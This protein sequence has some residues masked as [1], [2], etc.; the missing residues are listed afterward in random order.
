MTF[1][2]ALQGLRALI[3]PVLALAGLAAAYSQ[4][5]VQEYY[6]PMPEAQIRQTFLALASNTGTTMDSTVSMVAAVSGTKIVYD[7]WEDGYEVNLDSPTQSTTEIWGDGN[8]ANGKPPGFAND[9]NG[10]P[11]GTVIALRNQ[12]ALPRNPSTFLYDGRDRVGA[13]RGIVMTRASWA[14]TPGAVLAG[15]AA[16]PSTLDWGTSF[17]IPVG[18]NEIYPTPVTSSMF[19]LTSLFVQASQP[20]TQVQIDKNADGVVDTT[21]TLGQ[22]ESYYVDRGVYRGATVVASKPVQVNIITGDI[23]G[24]YENRWYSIAPTAQWGTRYY[25]PVG[26][27]S[28]GNETFVFLYN[29]DSAA[30]TVNVTTRVGA[31][32]VSIPAKSNYI[33]QMPQDS[34]ASFINTAGKNF[35]AIATVGAKPTANNVYDWGFSLVQEADLTTSLSLGW[36]P[37]SS[38]TTPT[39]N[40]NPVWVTAVKNTTVYVDYNGDRAGSVTDPLGGKC[41]ASF[42]VSALQVLKLFDPDK[43]QTGMRVYTV[44]GT[45]IAGAWGE[46]P[47]TA[48]SGNPYLDAGTT[49]PA[50]PVPVVRKASAIAIDAN[51]AGLSIGDTLEYTITMDNAGLVALGNLLV[52]DALP[53]QVTYVANSTTRDGVAI[54]DGTTGTPFPLDGSGVNVPVLQRGQTTSFKYRATITS[55]G[56][57]SNTV[58]TSYAGVTSNNTVSVPGGG[59]A[60]TASFSVAAGTTTTSYAVGDGVYVTVT[61]PDANTSTTTVQTFTVI[62]KNTST[63]DYETITLT[64]TGVN[65]GI[66]R[67][68]TALPSSSTAGLGPN[69]GTLNVFS[70]NAL[71]VSYTDPIYGETA[72]ASATIAAATPT[73]ILY[74]STDGVGSPDQDLDRIDPVTSADSST[75][76]TATITT[77]TATVAAAATTSGGSLGPFSSLTVAHTTGTGTNRLMMVAVNYEDDDVAGMSITG[78]TYGGVALTR[79]A[80]QLSG[81]EASTQ[82][83]YLVNPASGTAN[84]VVNATG[85]QAADTMHVGVTTFTGVSQSAPFGTAV[86]ATGTGTTASVTA[87]SATGELVYATLALDDARAATTTSGQTEL[88]NT[89]VGTA[90]SDGIRSAATTKAGALATVSSWTT[91]SDA[92]ACI[93]VPIKP[94]TTTGSLTFTQTPVLAENLVIPSGS[95]LGAQAYFTATTG[96]MPASP[97]VTA[98]L[99][100]GSTTIATSSSASSSGGILTFT[101]PALSSAVTVPSGQSIALDIT[102]AVAGVVFRID[103]DS[104]TKPSRITL[105]TSTV[106]HVDSVGVYDAPYPN[107]T[108]VSA[109]ANGQVLYVRTVAGDPFG[110]YDITSLPLSIDG[111]GTAG[112]ISTTLTD[113]NVVASTASSKTYEYQWR[114]G[115]TTGAYSIVATAKEGLENTIQA[116]RS[117]S[118][119]LANLDVGTPSTVEFFTTGGASTLTYAAN[120][121]IVVRVTDLDENKNAAAVETVTVTV[122]SS[123]GDSETITLTETGVN[124]GIFTAT[125]PASA[126][127]VGTSN[128]GTLY[129]PT[130]SALGVTYVDPNDSTDVSTDS[131]TVPAATAVDGV[132]ITKTL[133]SPADGQAIAGEAVQFRLRVLNTGGT[134]L[135]TVSVTDTFPT[136]NLTY[137]SATTTPT[138][139]SGGTITWSNVGP[140]T[141][142]QAAEI[143]VNFTANAAGGTVTNSAAVTAGTASSN[144]SANLTITRPRVTV[145]KTVVSPASGTAGKGD[146]VVFSIAIQNSGTT[147]IPTLPL[148]DLY[149]GDTFEYV[150]SSLTP[151]AT[152]NGTILWNDITGSGSLAVGATQTL[153]V[154]LKVKGSANPAT[155]TAAVN[156]AVDANN[157]S[158]PATSGSA[159][160]VTSAASISGFT[161]EDKGVS[162]FGG[163]IALPGVA[164]TLYTDPNG[165]GNPSDGTV[166][167]ITTSL[168]DGSYEFLNLALGNYVVVESD[169]TGYSSVTDIDGVND[170]RIKVTLTTLTATTGRNFLDLYIDPAL[171]GTINGQV[172]NDTDGDGDLLDADTGISGVTVDLYTDPNGDGNPLDGTIYATATTNASGNYSFTLVPPGT[173]VVVETDLSGYASTADKTL[174]NDNRVPVTIAAS[175]TSAANDFLDSNNLTLLGTIGNTVWSDVNN[176]GLLD[177]GEAGIANVAVQLYKST[178]T[179]GTDTP[180]RTTTT[181]S[182]GVYSFAYVPAGSYVVY[183]PAANFATGGALVSA[184]LSSDFTDTADNQENN[185]DNGIQTASGQPVRSPVIAIAANETDNT[186]DF[187]FV[188]NTSLGSISGTVLEDTNNDNTGD[189]GIAGVT[190]TLYSDP[191]GDGNQADGVVKG[192]AVTAADG[193]Y[194][195]T[196]LPP[197]SYVVVETQP[198]GY[199]NVTDTD[200]GV[201]NKVARTLTAGGSLA[202]SFVEERPGTVTGHLYIDTNGNGTQ[203][204]GEPNLNGVTITITDSASGTVTTTTGTNGNW[205][206]SVQPGSASA[207]VDTASAQIPAGAVRTEGTDPTVVTVT[208]GGTVSAGND[209]FYQSATLSGLVYRDVNGNGAQN[210]GEPGLSGVKVRITDVLGV[211]RD[212]T[213]NASGVWTVTL[214][215][216]LATV[217][218]LEL[219]AT[220]PSGGVHGE[221]TDPNTVTAVAGTTTNGGTDGYYFPATVTGH[222]Y[223]DTNGD[224][225]QGAGEP[226]LANVDVVITASTGATQR[227]ATDSSGNWTASVPPGTT[228]ADID[229]TDP[230]YPAGATRT[231]GDDPT[232]FTAVAAQST[233]GGIDGLYIPATVTGHLYIDRNGNGTEDSGELPLAGVALVITDSRS[234][235]RNVTTDT[236]GNWTVSVPPGTTIADIVDADPNIPSGA[237]RTEGTDPTT[238]TAVAGVS[239]SAGKDGFYQAATLTGHL[240]I[241]TNGNGTQDGAETGLA[242]VDV[243]ITD[244]LGVVRVVSTNASGNWTVSVPPGSA[245]VD[246]DNSDPQFPAGGTISQGSDPQTVTAVAGASTP[247]ATVGYRILGLVTGHLYVDVNNNGNQDAGEPNLSNI[248]VLV[249]NSLSQTQTVST[250]AA[251]NWVASVP[252]GSTTAGIDNADPQFPAG[253]TLTQGSDPV[254]V[255]AVA[256][257]S[258]PTTAV[259][260]YISTLVTGTVFVDVNHNGARDN[261]EPG[262]AG[263]SVVVTDSNSVV[264]TVVTNSQ[265]VWSASVAPGATTTSITESGPAFPSGFV[266]TAGSATGSVTAV[267]GTPVSVGSTGY[268]FPGTLSGHL[269]SDTN[270]NGVE[271]PGEPGLANISVLITD[272]LGNTQTVVTGSNGNWTATV[273]PGSTVVDIDNNDPDLPAG[274]VRT[275]GVDPVTVTAVSGQNTSAGSGTGFYQAATVAG[276]LYRDTNGNG[277]QD[278]GEPDLAN[279]NVFVTSSTGATQTVVSGING[280]WTASVPPGTTTI[281]VDETDPQYPAGATQTQGVALTTV[282]AAAGTTVQSGA[283]GFFVP[284]V[285]TGHL[286]LDLNGNG[287]QDFVFHNLANVDVVVTDSLGNTR[288]VFTDANGDW[289]AIVPPGATTAVISS[290]DP[291]YPAGSVVTQGSVSTNFTAIAGA[292]TGST[293]VGFFFPAT[294][295]GRLYVDTNGNGVQDSGEPGLPNVDVL[296]T[297]A[298]NNTQRVT[299]DAS[300][301][302]TAT[303]PPGTTTIDIDN[304]DPQYPTGYQQTQGTDPT[305]VTA[306]ASTTVSAGSAGFYRSG[307]VSGHLFVDTNGN[308]VED[309]GEPGLANV[310]VLV[311]DVNGNTQTVTTDANGNWTATVPPGSTLVDIVD[312]DPQIPAGATRTAG[313]D[314]VTVT[315]VAGANTPAGGGAGYYQAATLAGLLYADTNGNGTRDAG[316]PGIAD[317]DV[318]VTDSLGTV[319]RVATDVNGAWTINIPPGS[320]TVDIDNAD[321]Q[322][323]AGVTQ[324]EGTD[325]TTVTAIAGQT[326]NAGNDAYYLP[327]TVTGLVYR[328]VNGDGSLNGS[329]AG[330]AGVKVRVTDSLGVVRVATTNG[331]GV[332]TVSVPPGDTIADVLELDGTFPDGAVHR[333]GTDPNTVV[334]VAGSSVDSGRDGYY[335]PATVTGF[336]FLDANGNGVKDA[337]E[338]GIADLDVVIT[339][340]NGAVQTVTTDGS[341]NWTATVPP[342]ATQVKVSESD[343]Q[344]PAGSQQTVGADPNTITAVANQSVSAGTDGFYIAAT[345]TGVVYLDANGNGTQQN[346]E[347]GIAGVSVTITDSLGNPHVVT[348]GGDGR[349]TAS[350]PPGVAIV[351]VDQASASIPSGSVQTQG[352][353]PSPVTAVAGVS[354]DAGKDGYFQPAV[355]SGH[356]YVDAN[357][358]GVQDGAE[359]GLADVDVTI[360][361]SLGVVRVVSTD[362]NGNWTVSVPPGS[363]LVDVNQ[364]DPQFPA[365]GTIS[366]GSDPQ[367]VT[368]VAGSNTPAGTIGYR[369]LGM[370]TGHLYV[371][372]NNNATQDPGEPNL[373]GIN[374][375]VTDTLGS[376]TVE[377]DAL[378]NWIANVAPGSVTADVDNADPQ[379]PTGATLTEGVDPV[380]VTAVAGTSVPTGNVGYYISTLVNGTIFVDVNHN[381]TREPNEPGLAGVSVVVTDSNNVV[382]T[383]VTNDQGVWSAGVA[384]GAVTTTIT[385]SSPL[386]TTGFVRTSGS[387]TGSV[388]ATAGTPTTVGAT[389]YYFPGTVS[390]SLYFDTNGNGQKDGVESFLAGVDLAITDSNGDLTIV[391]T[392]GNGAWSTTVAP[393]LV[394]IDVDENDPQF[395]AG[396]VQT[397]GVDPTVVTA[398]SGQNVDSGT[399]GF[400]VSALVSGHLYRDTNGNGT[401]D[402]GEPDL[403]G[404]N[405]FVVDSTG[406]NRT[407]VTGAD[408][409]WSASVPPG[410][411]R[412]DIDETDPQYPAGAT[413]TQGVALTTLTAVAGSEVSAGAAGYFVPAIVTGHLYLDLNGNGQ[414]DFVY[415]NLANVDILVTDSLGTTRTVTTDQNGDWRASVPPGTTF[416]TVDSTD[417]EYPTGSVVTQGSATTNFTAIAGATTGSTPVGFF[418]PATVS[419]RLYV[420]TNGNGQADP[421][422]PGLANVDVL[423]TSAI[424]NTQRV[425]T[426]ANGNWIATVPPGTT[427]IDIDNADPQFP[428]GYLQTQGTDPT[429]ITAVAS[430]TVSAGGAG[431]YLSGSVSGHLFVDTNGNG[432]ED[433][434]EP[435]LAGVDV[436]VTDSNGSTQTVTTDANGNWTAIVPPGSTTADIVDSDPQIPA[437]AIRTAGSD[438]VTVTAVAGV[439]TP[440]G[441]GAG[442]FQPAPLS[443]VVY[444]DTNGN[445]TRNADEPGIADVDVIVTDSLGTVRRVA[446]NANGGWSISVPPGTTTVDVDNA[447]PQFPAGV[448]LTEGIDPNTVTAIAGQVVNAGNDGYFLPAT[449]TGLVY[450]DA[451]GDGLQNGGEPGLAGVKVRVTDILGIPHDVTTDSNGNWTAVVPPGLTNVDVLEFDTTFPDGGVHLAGNDPNSIIAVAGTTVNGGTDGYYFPATV[452]G[453]LYLDVDGNGTQ[454]AG[455]PPLPNVD[456]V[457]TTS[458]GA[459]LRVT[460]DTNGNWSAS[461]PPGTTLVDVDETDP[462]F[463]A[464]STRTQGTDPT[465]VTAVA[466][467]AVS[468]GTNGYHVPAVITGLVYL[469]VNGNGSRQV[470][471]PGVAGVAVLLTDSLNN[472][473]TVYTAADGTWVASVPPGST[474][475]DISA[476]DPNLPSG[477]V[478]TEGTNP[479]TVITVAGTGTSGGRDGFY[480][481]A[482]VTGHLYVDTNG[483]GVQD[484]GE[485]DLANVD[486][487]ITDSNGT[488]QVVSTDSSGNWTASVPP[489]ATV[490]DVSQADPQFPAGG[491][492]SQGTDP[493]TVNAV[494]GASTAAVPVGYQILGTVTGHLYVDVN[495]N[496]AQDT[497]EPDLSGI[498]V[499]VTDSAGNQQ[500]VST[501]ELGVW[502]A[503]VRP[504]STT[505]DV[506]GSDPQFPAGASISQG[507]DPVSVTA[508][509]GT[510]V[511]SGDLGYYIST[512][513]TGTVFV[514]VNHNGTRDSGEPGLPGVSVVVTDSNGVVNSVLTNNNGLWAASVAPGAVSSVISENGPAFPSGFVRTAGSAT[515]SATA[516]GGTPASVGS[517][518]YYFPGI[519]SGHLF[520]DT[521]GNG[522]EDPG[523]PGLANITV[524][525]TDSL[526]DPHTV[527]TDANGNWTVSVPP[528]TTTVEIDTADTDIPAGSVQTAG[529]N[530]TTVAVV[531][532]QTTPADGSAGFYQPG[533]VA[534]H[535]YRDT[536]GNGIQ[537][538]GEPDLAGVNVF[539]SDSNDVTQIVVTGVN[540]NWSAQ[541]PPGA[542]QIDVDETDPQFPAGA[543]QT[544]GTVLTTVNAAAGTTF[545]TTPQ[546]FFVPA[547]V[548]GHLYLDLNGNSQ[549]DF[550]IH[551]LANVDVLVTDSLGNVTRVTTD[552]DGNWRATVPPGATSATVDSTD[553]QYPTGSVVT[554]GSATTNFTAVAGVT[555]GSTPVGFFYPATVS[556]RVY[557]DRNGNGVQDS[558]EP[559]I[560]D[561]DLLV[562]SAI[563]NTQRVTTDSNGNWTATVPPGTTSIDIDDLDPQF[564]TGAL[565]T[566]GTD[567]TTV[568]AVASITTSAGSTGYYRP[569]TVSGHLFTDVNGNGAEDSGEP[570]LAGVDLIIT[571]VNGATQT[572]TTDTNG[573]WTATVPPGATLVDIVDN[574]PQIPAGAI[575]TVG[576]DPVTVTAVANTD[577]PVPVG[578]G[579]FQPATVRGFVRVDQQNDGTPDRGAAGVTV[580]LIGAGNV[581]LATTTTG[582]DGSYTFTGVAPGSD[583]VRITLPGGYLSVLDT[584]GGDTLVIGD[585]TPVVVTA[586]ATVSNQDFLLRPLK[587]PNRFA[588]WQA[589]HPLGG[590]NGPADNPD[591][592]LSNNLIEY[593]FGID[594][595]S[596]AGNPFCLVKSNT[597]PNAIDAVYTRTAGGALDVTYR[598][599]SLSDLTLAP[600]GWTP[601][602]VPP[603]SIQITDNG[604]GTETVRILDLESV[605]GLAG[606]GFV[607]LHVFLDANGDTVPEA[608]AVTE[609]GGWVQSNWGTACRTYNNAFV[610]CPPFSGVIDAVNGQQL[611]LTT[612]AAGVNLAT[613]LVPGSAYYLEV[614]SGD[615]AGH[616]FDVTAVGTGVLTLASDNNLFAASPPFNTVAGA[617]PSTL[618]GDRFV[619]RVHRTLNQ[620]FP[621][622]AFTATNAQDTADQV[623]TYVAGA[624]TSYWLYLNGGSPKWVRVDDGAL[625]DQGN[626]I[627]PPGQGTFINCLGA[628]GSLLAYGKVRQNDFALP[629]AAGNNLVAGGYPLAESPLSR[630]MTIPNGFDGDRDYKKADQFF[631]WRGDAL[632]GQTGYDTYFLLD[633]APVQPALRRW[634]KVGDAAVTPR[635]TTTLFKRDNSAFLKLNGPL[636]S[637]KVALPW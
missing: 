194:S 300:G 582:A 615:W 331:S 519:I 208:G 138:G 25:S 153:T 365:G 220:F 523:E 391:T 466:T 306:V 501:N 412:I 141:Q 561:L 76:S 447:D 545:Q 413:Q 162:G 611:D 90:N 62:V 495:H 380:T 602:T 566:Q 504:G 590:Q 202:A 287:Q 336:V 311:T 543:V 541:V 47:A 196:G 212:V 512:L 633:G 436:L 40:G 188:P 211:V 168:S 574:D 26:T 48:G 396:A 618:A 223:I 117:T 571:D 169:P 538:S 549:Q 628:P 10:L 493:Q 315:A 563:N 624:F 591:G 481:A 347:N 319:R 422:E 387:A 156:Y 580:R 385:E 173:Y 393:G 612:S 119:N 455:E 343:P 403:A 357:G 149:S 388:T 299:T 478:R 508:V 126:T 222:L 395:P 510:T 120:E 489:G 469:D 184:P 351:D 219:D 197:G 330:L 323:P 148:E 276:H 161:Y 428:T 565:R 134:T 98:T 551:N 547:I 529:T 389:S 225:T 318:V 46:D 34:G 116:Q 608:D 152:G 68:T 353:D 154:T 376:Q 359:T 41:D 407:V 629:L 178:Q 584:D 182:S 167:A 573:N 338:A 401:Q 533:T 392:D 434:G 384:P 513:V 185:D 233:S 289:R 636:P 506:D 555:L 259:G 294:V 33:Y 132:S 253:A 600:G 55:A 227:V 38:E 637:H 210:G 544:Q 111:P 332:W 125:L 309:S 607:R 451:N 18:E 589:A 292:T 558:G 96:T 241:D 130:G 158:V 77:G 610:S 51:T 556:G 473:R 356:L 39:V 283:Q 313:S 60:A 599:E 249:T 193:S 105:P 209:G 20:G 418:F 350:V 560:A 361:D 92:W 176:N 461:V 635:D 74:L 235:T 417:P 337:S 487:S 9:P 258:V 552:Q 325:P 84:V 293:P 491:T 333:E 179:P 263:V 502:T 499:V 274:S 104:T 456:L 91:G 500:T 180:Y 97:A 375:T 226:S 530:P 457:L 271:D 281:D 471:E 416:A 139:I 542:T 160:L 246:V 142:G 631:L 440:V 129:A 328:D 102:T 399:S 460:T 415:H 267:V 57:I 252:P 463:P 404:V 170:N 459:I 183:L 234:I 192:T 108:L 302:W 171:Y 496:G 518:G 88:F 52:L 89:T 568:T 539:V 123:S 601:V 238:V 569:G 87:V 280:N 468:G 273:P 305:T 215:P 450:R 217:D 329:E 444:L 526:N 622:E 484:S 430:T 93:S 266:R 177:S 585:V 606:A 187:G 30:I 562:T 540:G 230:Q 242:N 284:A 286:Y 269:F 114:T 45:L 255:T 150:S 131:A 136:A 11:A 488:V 398:V 532:G 575:R 327:A 155:N 115:S 616:R 29:P 121:S 63:G 317:V 603:G 79:L 251:G 106:I 144:S 576:S 66:F 581:T 464:D 7:H 515:G 298:I 31:S 78:V 371:D 379:F 437:G 133:I 577:T 69:D 554:Q 623:Q 483:N 588:G 339:D 498:D 559:G 525:I 355:V 65:T 61:D 56:S 594:P 587:E 316:E 614:V 465:T 441:G 467:Q 321:P 44:D 626:V 310:D 593:A 432:V 248:D 54:A 128:N 16:M 72:T 297:S 595:A 570:G 625:A 346:D 254:T 378:G 517:T 410:T 386:F 151:N 596:G 268:Y 520:S 245:T 101:F 449:V 189:T 95:V 324:T 277:T 402:S 472:T 191:N 514:D 507:T 524:V 32:S 265:G 409:N 314:P 239:T 24:N 598:L 37:G 279:V 578:V 363:T 572:V 250:D 583:L 59:T 443:G 203:D 304:A 550:L 165:D 382:K 312:T 604:D 198:S 8:D 320:A 12:I 80:T 99:R 374:V 373:S 381:G 175:Q 454:G 452:N 480:L 3:H 221:G 224:G 71:T 411:T 103:Y 17:V 264:R 345:V 204:S 75:A 275:A 94:A 503:S 370:V 145:T 243:K 619:I 140:L 358:N 627:I 394:H 127:T 237:V 462:Q 244:I 157:D 13:T 605:T 282:T 334:A 419:G 586:G 143:Y 163:D 362:A 537:D 118:V 113:T 377:T 109:P 546:G 553:P 497:G 482:T 64:E 364:A 107:G 368:A 453:H 6:V 28:N 342:G 240:Y 632:T 73:K 247:A 228:I 426:D 190:I 494:A 81:Q 548:T 301:N 427:T 285:V 445:G 290:S 70:G 511:A 406:V 4:S 260:Y 166:Q 205:S 2:P 597:N 521:N 122:T 609:V 256:G 15:A 435:G 159:T 408:G 438:P 22:G 366:Q 231:Q 257:S 213:T 516:V 528:G 476:A 42:Q 67:N 43:D 531:S 207:K 82:V 360:T 431:F 124:T 181:D 1:R 110:A 613:V 527:E 348:T 630:G 425:T 505:A 262:L 535:L 405:V 50:F 536:N 442:Y 272:S 354:S 492:I 446:T 486:V 49:I 383:V 291:E 229:E 534:G 278:S 479:T 557:V 206:A 369:I 567:P 21:V 296:V 23:G 485:P 83:W 367:T 322:F 477:V 397:Q 474:T 400:Y 621:P 172:R 458:T 174:P 424:N 372:V 326:V 195:F 522:V 564:P 439:D 307:T 620:V 27:A 135:S 288:T 420:D 335:F 146:N 340:S 35:Y 236:N 261:G 53:A 112:D 617:L 137:V 421:G 295:N 200:G 216:G 352:T 592:D 164:L 448:T 414:Q 5:I 201:D 270:G 344:Y 86:T 390:G 19:E 429:T 100:Y 341:G 232:T 218:V 634:A 58:S 470:G 36:G 14:T 147:A 509:A 303:V 433:S 308:G 423:V 349:W 199:L 85:V 579:Y 490:V 214:P 186:V 475:A